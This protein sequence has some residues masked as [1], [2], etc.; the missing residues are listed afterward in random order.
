MSAVVHDLPVI[1]KVC[2]IGPECTGKSELSKFLAA[3]FKTCW[4][5]EYA[6][7]YL[8][9]L[10][11]PYQQADLLKIAHGQLRLEDEW[12][13]D[14]NRVMICDTNLITIKIWSDYKYGK[15]DEEITGLIKT[16]AYDLYLLC[17]IDI[18]WVDDPQREH[19]DKRE[20]FWQLFKHEVESTTIPFVEIGGSWEQRQKK[21]VAA[22]NNVIVERPS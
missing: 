20:H 21:A 18:P 9:K 11:H 2:V 12:L 17:Y 19:P 15:C 4:I 16:R 13:R 7:A 3:H 10:G 6:R 5:P 1:K 14:S 22:V 8:D